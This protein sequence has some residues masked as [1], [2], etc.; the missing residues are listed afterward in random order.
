ML[1]TY[2]A[3]FLVLGVA[4]ASSDLPDGF[5]TSL[6]QIARGERVVFSW[7]STGENVGATASMS[8]DP[9]PPS[10]SEAPDMKGGENTPVPEWQKMV[11]EHAGDS[12]I[13]GDIAAGA[14]A[15][16]GIGPEGAAA[17]AVIGGVI[18][19]IPQIA[20]IFHTSHSHSDTIT[21]ELQGKGFSHI[22]I[23]QVGPLNYNGLPFSSGGQK[24]VELV[25]N[26]IIKNHLSDFGDSAT[27]SDIQTYAMVYSRMAGRTG[28]THGCTKIL[29]M[30]QR[31]AAA[32][33]LCT[34]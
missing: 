7:P 18:G 28:P 23:D 2:L 33:K 6:E 20:S 3:A 22:S 15:G 32:R 9:S 25:M 26:S 11:N 19:F 27:Q 1:A 30:T 16:A 24:P 29:S 17:G 21:G 34:S 12:Q 5:E 13:T 8:D 4:V 10:E 31:T 14:A